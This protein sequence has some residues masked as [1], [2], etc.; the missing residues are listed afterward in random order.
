MPPAA[1]IVKARPRTLGEWLAGPP[2]RSQRFL[3]GRVGCHQSMISM[4]VRGER[5]ARGKLALRLHEETGVPLRVLIAR[6]VPD[7]DDE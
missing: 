6:P 7:D 4:L 1:P 2:R 3:A 5:A